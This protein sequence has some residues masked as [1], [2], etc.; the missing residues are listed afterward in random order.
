[1]V[2]WLLMWVGAGGCTGGP[3]HSRD[4][5]RDGFAG[6]DDCDDRDP[7]VHP[8]ASEF[9]DGVDNDCDGE[10]DE[11]DALDRPT[12]KT[13][14]DG[15]GFSAP[16]ADSVFACDP[17]AGW[18][19][20]GGDCDDDDPT[21]HPTAPESCDGRDEDCNGLID[22]DPDV[23]R[24]AD[25]D[26]DG[27][28]DGDRPVAHCDTPGSARRAGDC[29]DGDPEVHPGADERCTG[30]D[31]DCDGLVDDADPGVL[32]LP[33]WYP[34]PDGDGFSDDEDITLV[35]C[36]P[37]NPF[38]A[39]ELGDCD[40]GD[41]TAFP[42][43]VQ[44]CVPIDQDCDGALP[45]DTAW[46]DPA[47]PVRIPLQLAG[48]GIE[49]DQPVVALDVDLRAALDAAGVSDSVDLEGLAVV[50]QDCTLGARRLDAQVTDGLTTSPPGPDALGD[51]RGALH[52]VYDQVLGVGESVPLALYL[53]GP[54]AP[55]TLD[56]VTT[57]ATSLDNGEL[58]V[59]F[60]PSRGGLVDDLVPTGGP[61]VWSAADAFEGNGL[62]TESTGWLS[63]G[64]A[65]GTV[66]VLADGPV[67][68][69]VHTLVEVADADAAYRYEATWW[70]VAGRP[71]L[72]GAVHWQSTADGTYTDDFDASRGLRPV[73][74]VSPGLRTP[75][76]D[77]DAA[78]RWCLRYDSGWGAL[79]GW[80]DPPLHVIE[81]GADAA[82]CWLAANE[83]SPPGS[84]PTDV[85]GPDTSL[86]D[87]RTVV[88]LPHA[89]VLAD[90]AGSLE[91]LAA[92]V[93]LI[94]AG[95]AEVLVP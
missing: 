40:N 20:D 2:W 35:Q 19:L 78:G 62:F 37:P 82:G 17:G 60:D 7:F 8:D 18:A 70:L 72:R 95:S 86:V 32:D 43:Q 65:A 41:P 10:V 68:G 34:D 14:G 59:S 71:E 21:R 55:A 85:V 44:G 46:W 48:T 79:V 75:T 42:G 54:A 93:S 36:D 30:V 16:G 92:P 25:D 91:A 73:Q 80:V 67:V 58:H 81:A 69:A 64:R 9:C 89:G 63:A 74:A 5:D 49:V 27:W 3:L 29:N 22:D 61:I 50:V 31:D 4:I 45:D 51:E 77:L 39:Q 26:G 52:V 33:T 15:D 57:S 13:D 53:Q 1:M 76:V 83:V 56:P 94:V 12:W 66:E 87:A 90:P 38:W 47:Y 84:G 88:V 24:Y 6:R 28:G 11:A 23:P